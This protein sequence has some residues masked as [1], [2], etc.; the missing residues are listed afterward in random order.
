M[1][2][3]ITGASRG[4]GLEL[5]RQLLEHGDEVVALARRPS[6]S[7]NLAA[8]KDKFG[9]RLLLVDV[10]LKDPDMQERVVAAVQSW[11]AVDLLIN[12]AGILLQ[13]ERLED[14]LESFHVNSVLPFYLTQALLPKLRA[15]QRP[16]VV[17]LTSKMGSIADNAS[18][19]HCAYRASKTALNM[20]N[21]CLARDNSWLTTIVIHPGWVKTDMGGTAAP[22]EPADSAAGI[23]RVAMELKP[24]QS[25]Q[26][27][28][29]QGKPLP[30]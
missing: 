30:W 12:N 7:A 13:G 5:T 16:R 14:F 4:I 1:N 9:G 22:V 24:A 17:Q 20:L 18:G 28:D 26:F 8:L 19:G 11:P 23:L 6:A 25:G 29:Y 27:F 10:N 15:S 3:V 2:V 21:M